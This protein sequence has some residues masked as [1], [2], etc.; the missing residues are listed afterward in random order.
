MTIY[1]KK[2]QSKEIKI[3]R[4]RVGLVSRDIMMISFKSHWQQAALFKD[5]KRCNLDQKGST[6]LDLPLATLEL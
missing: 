2:T 3:S 5:V 4:G 1:R 6:L